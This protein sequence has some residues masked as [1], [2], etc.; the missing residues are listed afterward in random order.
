M[1]CFYLLSPHPFLSSVVVLKSVPRLSQ[2]LVPGPGMYVSLNVFDAR[3]LSSLSQT[4]K[5]EGI[6]GKPVTQ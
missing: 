1:C 5:A 2:S 6:T 4:R 3:G